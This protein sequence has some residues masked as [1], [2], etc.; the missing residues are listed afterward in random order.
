MQRHRKY[1]SI[2]TS[3]FIPDMQSNKP[4][5]YK[6]PLITTYSEDEILELIGHANTCGSAEFGSPPFGHA[7]GYQ[8]GR[9]HNH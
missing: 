7:Y 5:I 3:P 1:P 6:K 2:F 8:H 9:G 4:S